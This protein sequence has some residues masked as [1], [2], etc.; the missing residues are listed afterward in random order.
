MRD[1]IGRA[2]MMLRRRYGIDAT[3]AYALLVKVAEQQ[4]RSINSV[5]LEVIERLPSAISADLAEPGP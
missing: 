5:A 1:I 4:N 2:E 3:D